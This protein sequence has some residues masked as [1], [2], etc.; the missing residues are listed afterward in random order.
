MLPF[1]LPEQT[2]EQTIPGQ[3][4]LAGFSAVRR[5]DAGQLAPP[6]R[7]RRRQQALPGRPTSSSTSG[8]SPRRAPTSR[9]SSSAT[10]TRPGTTR[11]RRPGHHRATSSSRKGLR[12]SRR[13][14][15]TVGHYSLL[16]TPGR[17]ARAMLFA[18]D[19]VYTRPALRAR[20]PARVPHRSPWR[21]CARSQRVKDVADEHGA[22]I[23]FSHDLEALRDLQARPRLLRDVGGDDGQARGQGGDRHRRRRRG[24]ARRSPTS[25]PTRGRRSSSRT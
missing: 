24:S 17:A 2:P 13:P 12:C 11:A 23:F 10:R 5:D 22:D 19:V 18:F 1:E 3:L 6:L 7:P 20:H 15:H 25:S 16:V 21:A 9:S 14:G 8:S 4:A